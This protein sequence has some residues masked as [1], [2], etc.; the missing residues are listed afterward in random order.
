MLQDNK[1]NRLYVALGSRIKEKR[2]SSGISQTDFSNY[3]GISRSSL[4]NIEKGRQRTPLHVIYSIAETLGISIFELIPRP[5]E[6]DRTNDL[7]D[8]EIKKKADFQ[9]HNNESL[10][11]LKQFISRTTTGY[12]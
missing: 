4:V 7:T 8:D 9:I 1:V 3:V 6:L 10:D 2:E 11:K 5:V 12:E